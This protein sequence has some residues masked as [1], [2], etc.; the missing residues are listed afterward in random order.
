M[1]GFVKQHPKHCHDRNLWSVSWISSF[2][3]SGTPCRGSPLHHQRPGRSGRGCQRCS[4]GSGAQGSGDLCR[5]Q[6]PHAPTSGGGWDIFRELAHQ[7]FVCGASWR[8]AL[9][10]AS[11]T[12]TGY[13][14]VSQFCSLCLSCSSPSSPGNRLRPDP[15]VFLSV[16]VAA[17]ASEVI[18]C[19]SGLGCW[20]KRQGCAGRRFR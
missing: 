12:L 10:G 17:N 19:F 5:Q 4:A 6:P 8:P 2:R 14:D 15:Q 18:A 11:P 3:D 13:F 16:F 1:Q 20:H 7:A 9:Q